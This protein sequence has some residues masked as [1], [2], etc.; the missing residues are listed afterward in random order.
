M[1]IPVT[2]VNSTI[3][4]FDH[5]YKPLNEVDRKNWLACTLPHLLLHTQINGKA[6]DIPFER[7]LT[8]MGRFR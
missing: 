4:V 6:Y 8:D 2:V 5:D 3:D 7:N 1:V